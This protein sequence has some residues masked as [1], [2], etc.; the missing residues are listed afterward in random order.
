L[1]VGFV[2][3]VTSSGDEE[4]LGLLLSSYE[5]KF[6]RDVVQQMRRDIEQRFVDT[7]VKTLEAIQRHEWPAFSDSVYKKARKMRRDFGLLSWVRNQNETKGVAPNVQLLLAARV[8]LD[9]LHAS[10]FLTDVPDA[11]ASPADGPARQ[12]TKSAATKWAQRF[13]RRWKLKVEK[14]QS[15]D[16]LPVDDLR[17]KAHDRR[18][19]P[20]PRTR[21]ISK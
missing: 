7:D 21:A 6:G 19:P 9:V 5:S 16:L 11:S 1:D 10:E 4:E 3:F 20:V 8:K 14:P 15:R 17:V 2:L 12:P 13:R 18:P